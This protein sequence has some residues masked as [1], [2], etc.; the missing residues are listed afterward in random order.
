[1]AKVAPLVGPK[2][3]KPVPTDPPLLAFDPAYLKRKAELPEQIFP[4]KERETVGI[5][6][7]R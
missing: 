2:F 4:P 6:H 5:F 1:M 3:K 7:R